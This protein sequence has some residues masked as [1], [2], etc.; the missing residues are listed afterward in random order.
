[1]YELNFAGFCTSREIKFVLECEYLRNDACQTDRSLEIYT[2]WTALCIGKI[3]LLYCTIKEIIVLKIACFGVICPIFTRNNA[4]E[5]LF[6]LP[7]SYYI[8]I[9]TG[10]LRYKPITLINHVTSVNVNS[11]HYFGEIAT[12]T[13]NDFHVQ[14]LE[15]VAGSEF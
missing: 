3:Q 8:G 2:H 5:R 4:L 12:L 11:I 7:G 13:S 1:M 6:F 14:H 10:D 15:F 9:W